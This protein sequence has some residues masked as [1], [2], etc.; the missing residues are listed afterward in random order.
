MERKI[1]FAIS[2]AVCCMLSLLLWEASVDKTLIAMNAFV[3]LLNAM[4]QYFLDD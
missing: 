1:W 3:G 4:L 2:I